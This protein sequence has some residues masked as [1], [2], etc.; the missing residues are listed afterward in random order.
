MSKYTTQL[1]Y[2]CE[3][4]AGELESKGYNSIDEIINK[5][6]D[7]IFSFDYPIFDEEYKQV[8]ETKI[9]KRYYTREIA[10]ETYGRWKLFLESRLIEIMPFYNQLYESALIKYEIFDD[11]NYTRSGNRTGNENGTNSNTGTVNRTDTE[12]ANSEGWNKYSDTPQ[13]SVQNIDNDSYLTNATKVTSNDARSNTTAE[14]RNDSGQHQTN[15]L[16]NYTELIKGKMP[17]KSYMQMVQEFRE[18]FLNIDKMIIDELADLFMMI[19]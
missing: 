15:T 17:G 5:S 19:Y 18:T 7:K 10:S 6:R 8:L 2:I 4:L 9:I 1:R 16:E 11:V 14:N 12:T 3:S 13:G